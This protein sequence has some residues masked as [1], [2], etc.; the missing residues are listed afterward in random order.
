L[1][2]QGPPSGAPL[3]PRA[4]APSPRLVHTPSEPSGSQRSPAG[5][6]GRSFV[7]VAGAIL[8]KQTRGQNPEKDEAGGSSPPR[9]T[10]PTLTSGNAGCLARRPSGRGVFGIKTSYLVTVPCHE[11][12]LLSSHDFGSSVRRRGGYQ[13]GNACL[14]LP[15]SK[16]GW[17]FAFGG[18][19]EQGGRVVVAVAEARQVVALD[20]V[21]VGEDGVQLA[22]VAGDRDAL[23]GGDRGRLHRLGGVVDQQQRGDATSVAP[24]V[25]AP[26]DNVAAGRRA[27]LARQRL[28]RLRPDQPR[29]AGAG[30]V[31]GRAPVHTPKTR[32]PLRSSAGGGGVAP[33]GQLTGD[34]TH[35]RKRLHARW[36]SPEDGG[37][38]ETST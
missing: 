32:S 14:A 24:R 21:E 22:G 18:Y 27:G 7:Q 25:A 1:P 33:P 8:R 6:S 36:R 3:P 5:S 12:A 15:S 9:P 2:R 11:S 4:G 10:A 23:E 31:Q 34:G 30:R 16:C 29:P 38:L 17:R 37:G 20:L 35:T 26:E 28:G 13:D 19:G